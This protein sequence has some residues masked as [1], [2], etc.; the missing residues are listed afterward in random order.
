[1]AVPKKRRSKSKKRIKRACWK[2]DE[3]NLRPCPKCG[4]KT[5]PHQVC[6]ECGYYKNREVIQIKEK[7]S[8]KK[9]T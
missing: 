2:I 5:M 6:P 3:P 7:G 8:K 9:D 4:A 1:M